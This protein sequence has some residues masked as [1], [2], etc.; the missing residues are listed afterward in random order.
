MFSSR[1]TNTKDVCLFCGVSPI[2]RGPGFDSVH[3][4]HISESLYLN[5]LLIVTIFWY[6]V[7]SV[8]VPGMQGSILYIH[9]TR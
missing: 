1:C 4:N 3:P 9:F 6:V 5:C 7:I 2:K 8:A